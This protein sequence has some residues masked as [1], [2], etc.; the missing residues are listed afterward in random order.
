MAKE[1][2]YEEN[3]KYFSSYEWEHKDHVA[4]VVVGAK[5]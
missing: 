2:H 3:M 1:L 5:E 4:E